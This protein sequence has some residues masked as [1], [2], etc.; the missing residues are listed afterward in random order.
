[1]IEYVRVKRGK[2]TV[3]V[4]MDLRGNATGY[5]LKAKLELLMDASIVRQRLVIPPRGEDPAPVD[6][7]R[8]RKLEDQ[9]S[10]TSQ[11][12][13]DESVIYLVLQR[14]DGTYEEVDEILT[15]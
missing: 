1:M 3:F 11:G 9:K 5:D 14:D 2:L 7:L 13:A 12:V 4:R 6:V 15:S 10:L 8:L